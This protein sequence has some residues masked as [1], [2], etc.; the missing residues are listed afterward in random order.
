MIPYDT[1]VTVEIS[2]YLYSMGE[3]NF[4]KLK[5][6]V[7]E[8]AGVYENEVTPNT[9]L[10]DDLGI[11]GDDAFELLVE[12]GKKFNVD[13]S[14]FMAADYFKGEGGIDLIIDGLARLFTGKISSSGLKVLTVRDLEKGI[15]AGKL[16]DEVIN[17]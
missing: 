8:Q 10:Y 14:N 4:E 17:Q 16:D 3:S 6:F 5:D 7:V 12:Y 11:Y 15:L 13:V 1:M 9:R 2:K